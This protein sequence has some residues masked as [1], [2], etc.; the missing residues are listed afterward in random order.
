MKRTFCWAVCLIAGTV[1]LAFDQPGL[2]I[3]CFLACMVI[4]AGAK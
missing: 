2:A 3:N 1:L 4:Q